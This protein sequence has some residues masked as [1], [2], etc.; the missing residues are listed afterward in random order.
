MKSLTKDRYPST[1][2]LLCARR[3]FVTLINDF[4]GT[5][6]FFDTLSVDSVPGTDHS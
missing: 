5:G 1:S 3:K 2:V 4:K 6:H